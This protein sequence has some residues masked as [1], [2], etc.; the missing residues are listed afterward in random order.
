MKGTANP[1]EDTLTYQL[2]PEQIAS[3]SVNLLGKIPAAPPNPE[4]E[5]QEKNEEVKRNVLYAL[6]AFFLLLAVVY[7]LIRLLK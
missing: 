4:L 5:L 2:T 7:I 3:G 1:L 6:L